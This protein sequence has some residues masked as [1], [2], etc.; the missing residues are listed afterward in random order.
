MKILKWLDKHLEQS[1]LMLLLGSIVI[2]MLYQII[3]RYFF[4]YC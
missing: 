2:V 3:R 4:R 1:I